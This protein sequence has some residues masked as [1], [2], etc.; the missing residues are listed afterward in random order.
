[1]SA[2]YEKGM[3]FSFLLAEDVGSINKDKNA[4]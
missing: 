3:Q 2:G 4:S 1:M